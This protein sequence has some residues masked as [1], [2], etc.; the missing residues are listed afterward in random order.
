MK[1]ISLWQPWASLIFVGRKSYET[2]GW[3]YSP[4]LKDQTIAIHSTKI[5]PNMKYISDELHEICVKEFGSDYQRSMLQ[6]S[7]L[8][9]VKLGDIIPSEDH[10]SLSLDDKITGDWSAGRFGWKLYDIQS[11]KEPII[12]GGKQGFW[13]VDDTLLGNY[14]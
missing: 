3:K 13:N 11:L 4:K 5:F 7:I 2:R 9:T 14:K 1:V 10:I 12:I 8:G 6:S